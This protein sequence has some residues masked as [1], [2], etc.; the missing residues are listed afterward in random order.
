MLARHPGEPCEGPPRALRGRAHPSDVG[1]R[2]LPALHLRRL[3][4]G[5]RSPRAN[6][7][8]SLR[9]LHGAASANQH[10][11]DMFYTGLLS[12]RPRSAADCAHDPLT[13]PCL[14]GYP[15]VRSLGS[16]KLGCN[17]IDCDDA[18]LLRL[19]AP[20]RLGRASRARSSPTACGA[21]ACWSAGPRAIPKCRRASP[22][23]DRGCK[24]WGGRRAATSASSIGLRQPA[25]TRR[26][27][28]RKSW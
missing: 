14:F 25:G 6:G 20:W 27:Y 11:H 7:A 8:A 13:E 16:W 10:V 1:V 23:S 9:T 19:P 18:T 2:R 17:S 5:P 24:G 22:H 4:P 26:G 12:R 21:S 3:R 28:L 15:A